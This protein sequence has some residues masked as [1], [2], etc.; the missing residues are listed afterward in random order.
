MEVTV[1]NLMM[2]S[3]DISDDDDE[4]DSIDGEGNCYEGC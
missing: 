1:G 4:N 3:D 2:K